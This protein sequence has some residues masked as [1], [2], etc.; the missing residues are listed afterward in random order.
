MQPLI[1]IVIA[2]YN[3][4]RFLETAIQSVLSQCNDALRL[5]NEESIELIIVDGGSEDNSVE[6]I[7]KYENK[8]AWWCSERDRGQSHAFNK[9]FAQAT[10]RF[11][12]WLNADDVMM[13]GGLLAVAI[14]I[15]AHPE[16]R[17]FVGSSVW[18]DEQLRITRCFRAHRFSSLRAR[19]GTLSVGSPSSFFLKSLLAEV[20]WVDETLQYGMD[21]EL[22]CRFYFRAKQRYRRTKHYVW[23][24]RI[25]PDSKVSGLNAV[26]DSY[27]ALTRRLA[28]KA[29]SME[30]EC[31]Y[32]KSRTLVRLVDMGTVSLA[33]G[34]QAWRET[35]ALRGQVF[36]VEWKR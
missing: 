29:E 2:N 25:H 19:W 11:L 4:G 16:C 27:A 22:W 18:M 1:S 36:K 34:L 17:W 13:P 9:G 32:G 7:R 28:Q 3:Y 5:P 21:M 15:K 6:V 24:F 10:G 20:G 8:L 30:I 23:G 26:P 12:T 31:R 35:K 33:D 14:E